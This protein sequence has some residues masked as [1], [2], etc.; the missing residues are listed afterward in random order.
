MSS[1]EVVYCC[2]CMLHL[3]KKEIIKDK[4]L[5]MANLVLLKRNSLITVLLW[6]FGESVLVTCLKDLEK[7][8]YL[9]HTFCNH[10]GRKKVFYYKPEPC[11]VI[12]KCLKCANAFFI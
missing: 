4:Q 3:I 6:Q 7:L 8:I 1:L 12:R 11:V 5:L 2:P 10:F 9:D